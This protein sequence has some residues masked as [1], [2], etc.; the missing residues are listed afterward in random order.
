MGVRSP[1]RRYTEIVRELFLLQ[2]PHE[3]CYYTQLTSTTLSVSKYSWTKVH[4]YRFK[5]SSTVVTQKYPLLASHH[6]PAWRR[7]TTSSCFSSVS[8][9]LSR[10]LL[11]S[12]AETV[13]RNLFTDLKSFWRVRNMRTRPLASKFWTTLFAGSYM[14]YTSCRNTTQ[15]HAHCKWH[16]VNTEATSATDQVEAPHQIGQDP[17]DKE[18][19]R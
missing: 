18:A 13:A 17:F 19:D 14:A 6:P 12:R 2:A 9:S 10:V 1:I 11:L 3:K 7:A 8:T 15:C 5:C 4:S 16:L